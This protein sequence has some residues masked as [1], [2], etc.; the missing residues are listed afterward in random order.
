MKMTAQQYHK[1]KKAAHDW[2]VSYTLSS[3]GSKH[4]F[5]CSNAMKNSHYLNMKDNPYVKDLTFSRNT[6]E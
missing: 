1:A 3:D 2:K 5:T 6:G 4:S